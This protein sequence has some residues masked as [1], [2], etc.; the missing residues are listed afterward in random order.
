MRAWVKIL[1]D[2]R[3]SK[4]ASPFGNL[5]IQT[6]Y[7]TKA[8]IGPQIFTTTSTARNRQRMTSEKC[9]HC[10]V[11]SG[12]LCFCKLMNL[13]SYLYNAARLFILGT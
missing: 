1:C 9:N 6:L 5:R 13:N 3:L 4:R 12:I 8:C 11:V 10:H 7:S 2:T